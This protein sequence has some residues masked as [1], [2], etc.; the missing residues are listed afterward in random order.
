MNHVRIYSEIEEAELKA[1]SDIN[2]ENLK[3][4]EPYNARLTTDYKEVI[5]SPEIDAVSICVPASLHY[6]IAKEA[7]EAGKHVLV[8]KP[9]VMTSSQGKE[10]VDIAEEKSLVL[11]VGQVFRFDPTVNY[12]REEIKK[13]NFGRVYYISLSR[14]GLKNPREDIGAIFN[15]A[16]HDMD[17]MCYILDEPFPEEITATISHPL[18]RKFEDHAVVSLRFSNS[19]G[20]AQVG[21]L[22]P[23]KLREFW[24]VGEKRSASIN[25]I[26]FSIEIFNS[27]IFPKYKNWDGFRLITKEGSST[28]LSTEKKEPLKEELKY[29]IDCIKNKRIKHLIDGNVGLR[30]IEMA[31]AALKAAEEKRTVVL[32]KNGN[33][34]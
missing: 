34:V 21:W 33:K 14:L 25:P 27:G 4:A 13:G 15:Y 12:I 31:E 1:V 10:L 16:V 2:N 6:K 7:L 9:F 24:L 5:N 19:I 17:I 30:T 26:D 29:F 8:E 28:K 18:K 3:L 32:N 22:T 23:K 20:Y 11:A